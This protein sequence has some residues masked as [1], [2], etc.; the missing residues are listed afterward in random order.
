MKML[1]VL[2]FMAGLL[3]G[4]SD[5]RAPEPTIVTANTPT[6]LIS[7]STTPRPIATPTSQI[8]P[9]ASPRPATTIAPVP[10]TPPALASPAAPIL[11]E[12]AVPPGSH[13]HDVAPAPDG[14]VWYTAQTAEAL[15][16]LDPLTGETHHVALG[17]GSAPHG[18]IIG[19]DGAAWVTDGGL[20]AIVRVDAVTEEVQRFPLPADRPNANLNTAAFD[21]DGVL[22]FTGQ[23]GVYGRLDPAAGTVEVFDAPRGRG[24]YGITTTPSGE[25][26]YASLTGSHIAHIDRSTNIATPLEPPTSDQGA[27]RVW[28]DS[29]GR[30][31]VSEWNAG[32]VA[33]YDPATQA[34]REWRLPGNNPAAYAVYVDDRDQ[35][36]L[37]DF[38]ANALVRFDPATE[39]FESFTL[40]SSPA[41]VRQ[42]LGRPG[43]VWG[44][45]SGTDK[46]VVIRVP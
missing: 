8:E 24:P 17:S 7:P 19:P 16:R 39:E 3:G 4:C 35:V 11:Q 37:S 41:N 21:A 6:I 44:A 45:E 33:M 28:S 46:L 31:W 2:I 27:R 20:N 18:V 38:N 15:G 10:T 43:E 25:V 22:W 29:S 14:T 36:W 9:T 23:N 30:L 32:Q 13:P 42:M 1:L 34:W 5:L 40:P 26:Y 12:Y